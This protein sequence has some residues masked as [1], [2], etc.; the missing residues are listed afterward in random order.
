MY[1]GDENE[2]H[3]P[4]LT[5]HEVIDERRTKIGTVTDVLY[6]EADARPRWAAVSLGVFGG[7]HYVPLDEAYQS[8]DGRVVV[9][10]DKGTV[11]HAP[12]VRRDHVMTPDVQDELRR[13][14]GMAS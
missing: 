6:D 3:Q 1:P 10:Y 9:P 2:S 5:D 7:E 4:V 13:Y 14:Y 11:K 8:E 12:K